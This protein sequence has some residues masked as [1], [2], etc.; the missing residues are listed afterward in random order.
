MHACSAEDSNTRQANYEV[1]NTPIQVFNVN[2]ITFRNNSFAT[3]AGCARSQA[4]YAAPI[5]LVNV[6]N[7]V[8][9]S[10]ASP[11]V[12]SFQAAAGGDITAAAAPNLQLGSAESGSGAAGALP[13]ASQLSFQDSAGTLT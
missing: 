9:V 12:S 10:A 5:Y 1:A 7:V 8:G 3:D 11:G 2:G 4:N 6:T 13:A